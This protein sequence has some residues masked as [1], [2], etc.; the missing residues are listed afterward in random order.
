MKLEKS[1]SL[2]IQWI[3]ILPNFMRAPFQMW[4]TYSNTS[5]TSNLNRQFSNAAQIHGSG[6]NVFF[7]KTL[8]LKVKNWK[9]RFMLLEF[10]NYSVVPRYCKF[11]ICFN[12]TNEFQF[13][14]LPTTNETSETIARNLFSP[15]SCRP[16]LTY[17]RA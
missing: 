17:F 16:K 3:W 7:L 5:L 8:T 13:T 11:W 4:I 9:G 6:L 15:F 10:Q 2:K 1:K 14:G 12:A